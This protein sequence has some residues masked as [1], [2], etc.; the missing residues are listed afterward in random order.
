MIACDCPV[1]TSSDP[2]DRRTRCSVVFSFNDHALL[3][4][5]APELRLQALACN[6]RLIHAVWYTHAHADHIVGLDDLR[7]FN[8]LL[9][10]PLPVYASERTHASIQKMFPY[11][12]AEQ[13]DY[14]SAIPTLQERIVTGPFELFGRT[15]T[16]LEY[17]H[18][19][20]P[21]LGV[22]IGNIAY[23]PDCN[24]IP[25]STM[26][27]LRD[28]DVLVLDA[29]RIRPHPT[30]FN[31]EEAIE[32]ARRIG[33]ARTYFTHIA[34]ELMHETTQREL[35]AKMFMAHDGLVL[36]SD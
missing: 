8:W 12:F 20:T 33:A 21:V 36:E 31:L 6:I 22:R 3:V 14:P 29:L 19:Q 9:Q 32:A 4:D 10:G 24:R 15:V 7:R 18:G 2:R 35:P 26:S 5:T 23:M 25:D 17:W 27:L 1:C 11:A 28:L 30:H 13:R 34:H 16:P